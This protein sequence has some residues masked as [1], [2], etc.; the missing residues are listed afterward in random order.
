MAQDASLIK[1]R[2]KF[3][4]LV[5]PTRMM[6]AIANFIEEESFAHALIE[7][8]LHPKRKILLHG[9]SGCGKTSIAHAIASEFN[10]KSLRSARLAHRFALRRRVREE[11]RKCHRQSVRAK[12]RTSHGRV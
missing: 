4:D 2:C 1:P 5:Y 3:S 6:D 11:Y 9:P 10:L 12:M 7:E 8:G